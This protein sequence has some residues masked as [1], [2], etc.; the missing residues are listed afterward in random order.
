MKMTV[1]IF[2]LVFSPLIQSK[3]ELP[4]RL[5]DGY[6]N[7]NQRKEYRYSPY[8]G[9][10]IWH[11]FGRPFWKSKKQVEKKVSVKKL[12]P[13]VKNTPKVVK[14]K[15]IERVKIDLGV[16]FASSESNIGKNYYEQSD[17]LANKLKKH[18]NLNL[19]LRGHTDNTGSRNLNELLSKERSMAVKKYLVTKHGISSERLKTKGFAFDLPL[20]ENSTEVGKGRNR[21][22]EGKII[23]K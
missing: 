5:S 1:L 16:Y 2:L 7:V 23:Q 15:K 3:I 18:N 9:E 12:A 22:V 6:K 20:A 19:E 21:R 10:E 13:K 17:L 4:N 14:Q 11:E 8:P